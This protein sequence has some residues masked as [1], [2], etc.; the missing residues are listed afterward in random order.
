MSK[1]KQKDYIVVLEPCTEGVSALLVEL[2][3]R[4]GLEILTTSSV[5]EAVQ[6]VNQF[7]PCMVIGNIIENSSVA[8]TVTMLKRIEKGIKYGLLKT[9]M[10]SKIKSK[11]LGSLVT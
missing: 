5:D 6:V 4:D 3:K 10:V 7:M 11:Q 2:R 8:T 1:E 9:M